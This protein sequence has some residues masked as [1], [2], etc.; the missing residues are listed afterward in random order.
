MDELGV[1]QTRVKAM[2]AHLRDE[3]I[4]PALARRAMAAKLEEP[5]NAARYRKRRSTV[6]P[7]FGNIKANLGYR[8]FMR[9]GRSAVQSEWRLICAAHNLLKIRRVALA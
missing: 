3:A 2:L 7:V 9:R 4:E 1:S 8:H 5:S 6:E